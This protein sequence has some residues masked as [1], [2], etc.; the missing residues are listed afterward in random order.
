MFLVPQPLLTSNGNHAP[1]RVVEGSRRDTPA[2]SCLGLSSALSAPLCPPTQTFPGEQ[3][4]Q[5]TWKMT[6]CQQ[7]ALQPQEEMTLSGPLELAAQL[8][9]TRSASENMTQG[10]Y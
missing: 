5:C 4:V 9:V 1:E 8:P 7:P 3:T 10:K 6:T 2:M